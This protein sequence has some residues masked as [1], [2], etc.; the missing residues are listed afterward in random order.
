M[1]SI[2]LPIQNDFKLL[3]FSRSVD[4]VGQNGALALNGSP[5]ISL[6]ANNLTDLLALAFTVKSKP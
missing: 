1:L 2:L 3:F 4:I 5:G 6:R